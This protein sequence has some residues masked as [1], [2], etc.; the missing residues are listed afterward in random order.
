ME[1]TERQ[2]KI[3]PYTEVD[4]IRTYRDSDIKAL[5]EK[6]YRDGSGDTVFF[7]G[8]IRHADHFLELMKGPHN[9]LHI[10]Y[11]DQ[12]IV[13]MAWINRIEETHCYC[14]WLFFK[15]AW[16]DTIIY[17]V[18][19]Y[20]LAY[21]I[22]RYGFEVIMGITPNF[23]KLALRY[24]KRLGLQEAG[25]IPGILYHAKNDEAIPGTFMYI[26]KE[27]VENAFQVP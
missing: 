14:H 11:V 2:I 9:F 22:D 20:L 18:G 24:L 17:E 10:I 27:I 8:S 1:G 4:G 6:V 3:I 16:G 19:Q 12:K 13:A 25:T 5:Y 21:L 26:T 23:N 7:D 15:E